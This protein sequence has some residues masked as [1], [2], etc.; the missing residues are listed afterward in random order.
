MIPKYAKQSM[1][2]YQTGGAEQ[3]LVSITGARGQHPHD[4]IF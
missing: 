4:L 1:Q 3:L 2:A